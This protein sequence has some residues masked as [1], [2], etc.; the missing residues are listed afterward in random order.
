M[1]K[2]LRSR[3][4]AGA[5]LAACAALAVGV[6]ACGESSGNAGADPA[7]LI[8]GGTSLYL[9]ATVKPDGDQKAQVEAFLKK[10][11]RTNDPGAQIKKLIDEGLKDDNATYDEDIK[12]WL[13]DKAGL[14]V[15]SYKGEGQFAFVAASSDPDKGGDALKKGEKGVKE[16]TYRDVKYSVTSDNDAFAAIDDYVVAGS[17]SAV[18]QV[19]DTSKDDGKSLASNDKFSKTFEP[20]DDGI[21]RVYLDLGTLF[22]QLAADGEIPQGQVAAVRQV[23]AGIGSSTV[24]ATANVASDAF[25]LDFASPGAKARTGDPGDAAG[26]LASAPGDA[27]FALGLGNIR[28]TLENALKQF[29]QL[30]GLV[31]T[32]VDQLLAQLKE[33]SGLDVREDLINWMGDGVLFVRGTSLGDLGGALVVNSTDPEATQRGV[34]RVAKLLRRQGLPVEPLSAPGVDNGIKITQQGIDIFIASAGDKFLIGAGQGA[35]EAALK[36]SSTLGDSAGYKTATEKLGDGIKPSVYFD[37]Q[38]VLQL[39]EGLGATD[40]PDYQKAA[41]YLK[42]FT[43]LVAGGKREGDTARGKLVIGVR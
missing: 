14:F 7:A 34:A 40:D 2:T 28:G 31:G 41:P 17:E 5:A 19:I 24:G 29:S 32:D 39:A 43:T 11:M 21:G 36:P 4:R 1:L 3:T 6:S 37:L 25:T 22:N 9:E 26:A 27:W 10:V 23:F 18:K 16:R 15:A 12:P 20:L 33:Q 8:P 35:L 30:G 42:A 38:P 13:G